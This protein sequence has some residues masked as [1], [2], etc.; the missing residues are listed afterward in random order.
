M[1]IRRVYDEPSDENVIRNAA[2][3]IDLSIRQKFNNN[4]CAMDEN[5]FVLFDLKH[6]DNMCV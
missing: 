3:H 6:I 2:E 5:Q 4:I 1:N